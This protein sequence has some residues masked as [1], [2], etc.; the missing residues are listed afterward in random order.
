MDST[1]LGNGL[2]QDGAQLIAEER[3]WQ[4]SGEAYAPEHDDQYVNEELA[5]AAACYALAGHDQ[6][7]FPHNLLHAFIWPW[8]EEAWKPKG[9]LRN[10][11]RAGA[12]IA[13]EI[14]R[15]QRAT[16]RRARASQAET[17]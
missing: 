12:L 5:R 1:R 16:K 2:M 9:R 6:G 7:G 11:V 15:V 10:L 14:D 3:R 8:A 17:D 4:V 13:A